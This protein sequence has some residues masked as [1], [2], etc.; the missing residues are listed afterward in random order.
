MASVS[1]GSNGKRRILFVDP[2][3]N[4]KTIY[5]GKTPQKEADAIARHVE[6]ILAA[7]ASGQAI[8]RQT[9]I[10]LAEIGDV[11]HKKL[12][13]VGLVEPRKAA[14][15]PTVAEF[16]DAYIKERNDLASNSLSNMNQARGWLIRFVG[17]KKLL[18]QLTVA[19]VDAYKAHM[20]ASGLA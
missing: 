1:T 19:D 18:D 16:I 13:G 6:A 17:E 15:K 14:A 11:L 9:A 12:S 10:W 5:L 7:K 2:D 20:V 4:R 8:Q 3:G